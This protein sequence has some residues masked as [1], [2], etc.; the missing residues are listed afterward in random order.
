MSPCK[1][2]RAFEATPNRERIVHH[3]VHIIRCHAIQKAVHSRPNLRAWFAVEWLEMADH[4]DA[5]DYATIMHNVEVLQQTEAALG[6]FV[7]YLS[8]GIP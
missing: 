3:F 2:G 5:L 4:L 8:V 1:N 7:A 6:S